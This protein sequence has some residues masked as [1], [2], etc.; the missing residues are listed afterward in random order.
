M[1][2]AIGDGTTS[3]TLVVPSSAAPPAPAPT[4]ASRKPPTAA[5][6]VISLFTGAMGL[7]LG[8]ERAGFHTSVAVESDPAA[9]ATIRANRPN[10]AVISRPIE[11]VST[12]E[13][14]ETASLKVGDATL[15]AGGPACQ[16]F[17]TAGK[18]RSLGDPLGQLFY[19]FMR[20][21]DE[22]RPQFFLMENVR[23]LLSAAVRHRPL[24]RRGGKHPPLEADE[25]LGSAFR[26][27]TRRIRRSGYYVL[28]DVLDAADYGTPQTRRRLVLLGSRDGLPLAMPK[29]SHST[30]GCGHLP[31]WRTLR[32][33]VAT[34]DDSD[35][36]YIELVPSRRQY[37]AHVPPGGN[38]R[39]LSDELQTAALGGAGKSWGGRS[40][41]FR[42][43]S[44]DHPSPT[45]N[46]NPD[47]KATAL[48]HPT[49]LR[50]LTVREYARIQGF[51]DDWIV[52]GSTRQRY[53]QLGNAVPV[54]LGEALGKAILAASPGKGRRARLG[55][56]ECWNVNLLNSLSR[57]ARTRLNPPRMRGSETTTEMTRW[58]DGK[59]ARR[60]DAVD[61]TP[62]HMTYAIG[63]EKLI[64]R[65][66]SILCD[67]YESP[68][69]GNYADPVDELFFIILS[70]RTTDPS[71]R[72]VFA[73]LRD[74]AAD[75]NVLLER[76]HAQVAAVIGSA[77]LS[78]QKARHIL[79]IARQLRKDFGQVTLNPLLHQ[80]DADV[81]SYLSSL[82]GVGTKTAKCV[83]LFSMGRQVLPVDAHVA[84]VAN[85]IGIVD[86]S[87][88]KGR[89]G[90]VIEAVV[91]RELR[92]DFHVNVVAH[93]RALCRAR[94]PI[95]NPCP[96]KRV[97]DYARG[98]PPPPS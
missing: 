74:W 73:K 60:N 5:P 36:D 89:T 17:S 51:P 19:A 30:D 14:L 61:Y 50:P 68:D 46:T 69:L 22:A 20:V 7:D 70:Q 45:L 18:R 2:N 78:N 25:E 48:C 27:M 62:E 53:R 96:I 93:G 55:R 33:A 77:G 23:G 24:N 34:L 37:F 95:C 72:R 57:R 11:E 90:D 82:P 8:L 10:L 12:A 42:R 38:W 52:T 66:A 41:F 26:K 84:R 65:V 59:A 92:R 13:I 49:E 3:A 4:P 91:P 40:G 76:T 32:D 94:A 98:Q 28:F 81:E 21:V 97:C 83:M 79:G 58:R 39:D 54:A 16:S 85:R 47:S 87:R 63:K 56:V 75:W 86:R 64:R 9:V 31:P 71:Y 43:L 80:S 35:P 88:A 6:H 44:W 15:L 67:A 29:P 1:T